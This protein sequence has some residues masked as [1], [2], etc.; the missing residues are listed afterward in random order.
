MSLG[1]PSDKRFLIF[2]LEGSLL[3]IFFIDL[4]SQYAERAGGQRPGPRY[5]M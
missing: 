2:L 1:V 3:V 5:A 4:Y